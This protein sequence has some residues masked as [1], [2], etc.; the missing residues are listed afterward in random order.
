MP[1]GLDSITADTVSD[2]IGVTATASGDITI[3]SYFA[4]LYYELPD[5]KVGNKRIVPYIRESIDQ[6]NIHAGTKPVDD[7]STNG[8][9]DMT[10]S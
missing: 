5:H 8:G 4:T 1:A 7:L 3:T 9:A 2:S 6:T 10:Y